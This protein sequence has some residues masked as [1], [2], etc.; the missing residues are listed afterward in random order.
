M[1]KVVFN[2]FV[3]MQ[4]IYHAISQL[5]RP[6]NRLPRRRQEVEFSGFKMFQTRDPINPNTKTIYPTVVVAVVLK[7]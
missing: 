1:F 3:G 2:C 7:K 5:K 6:R 4:A